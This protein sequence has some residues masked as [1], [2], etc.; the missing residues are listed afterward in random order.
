MFGYHMTYS[1][2]L[3]VAREFTWWAKKNKVRTGQGSLKAPYAHTSGTWMFPFPL[4]PKR[5][6]P[7]DHFITPPASLISLGN[8]EWRFEQSFTHVVV[9]FP[10]V[11]LITHQQCLGCVFPVEEWLCPD[12]KSL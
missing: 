9:L 1:L 4:A 3:A 8:G 6:N 7:M 11:T 10:G 12:N 5:K 2:I